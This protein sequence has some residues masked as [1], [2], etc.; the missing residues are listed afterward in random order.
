MLPELPA[1]AC[2]LGYCFNTPNLIVR[3]VAQP[4]VGSKGNLAF[5][6]FFI[7]PPERLSEA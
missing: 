4:R 7:S 1:L 5:D 6:H 3:I 2:G